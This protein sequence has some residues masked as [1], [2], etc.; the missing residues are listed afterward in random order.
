M[1]P[2]TYKR[3][4]FWRINCKGPR[5]KMLRI[6]DSVYSLLLFWT[7]DLFK[8]DMLYLFNMYVWRKVLLFLSDLMGQR[9]ISVLLHIVRGHAPWRGQRSGFRPIRNHYHVHLIDNWPRVSCSSF[10][11]ATP[12]WREPKSSKQL[13]TVAAFCWF[14]VWSLSCCCRVMR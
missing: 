9:H 8:S 6:L 11:C 10:C 1:V 4:S 12:C 2:N 5:T 14:S 13:S 7:V 3:L